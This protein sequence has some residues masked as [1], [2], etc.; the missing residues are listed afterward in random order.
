MSTGILVVIM[1]LLR[2]IVEGLEPFESQ[3][4]SLDLYARDQVRSK[5]PGNGL[6]YLENNPN[7]HIY[8][9]N[10]LCLTGINASGKTTALNALALAVSVLSKD[11]S[12]VLSSVRSLSAFGPSLQIY[13]I[14]ESNQQFYLLKSQ[15][16]AVRN[17]NADESTDPLADSTYKFSQEQLW[18]YPSKPL[19]KS[20]LRSTDA[21]QQRSKLI[22]VRR[23]AAQSP[24]DATT[25]A[26]LTQEAFDYLSPHS[27]I[28]LPYIRTARPQVIAH[29]GPETYFPIVPVG[30]IADP[31]LH[32]F[33]DSIDYFHVDQEHHA[34]LRFAGTSQ[35]VIMSNMDTAGLLS[36]GTV[37]GSRIVK[38]AIRVLRTGGYLLIDEIENSINKELVRMI[39]NLFMSATSNPYGATLVFT[40]HYAELL[41]LIQRKDNIYFLRRSEDERKGIQAINYSE[42]VKRGE[43]KHSEVFLSNY[44]GG[45]A[46]K[47]AE[48]KAMRHYVADQ[49][50]RQEH[51]A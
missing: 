45:T 41:D 1:R 21:F 30:T 9:Q 37:R 20:V 25:D 7:S 8:A 19:P 44:I 13:L 36:L 31:V 11:A 14:F 10:V 48:L 51:H 49:V 34:H 3:T 18:R 29:I 47:A 5:T 27:S 15:L 32:V 16:D 39:I 26:Y 22:K 46:P 17:D 33:D 6:T 35:D 38:A 24:R 50:A 12:P 4:L 43:L 40:T 28:V 23:L 42:A 2:M